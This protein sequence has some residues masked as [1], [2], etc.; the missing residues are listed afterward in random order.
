MTRNP[1][2][3]EILRITP[4]R[5]VICGKIPAIFM[6]T[7]ICE[8]GGGVLASTVKTKISDSR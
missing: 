8:E 5:S 2:R 4:W 6:K 7:R 1:L 3:L